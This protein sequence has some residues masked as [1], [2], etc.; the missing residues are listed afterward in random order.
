MNFNELGWVLELSLPLVLA[1]WVFYIYF[2]KRKEQVFRDDLGRIEAR[3]RQLAEARDHFYADAS[4]EIRTPLNAVLG[5]AHM[6]ARTPLDHRQREMLDGIQSA[7]DNLLR[8]LDDLLDAS[9]M[10]A[11]MLRIEQRPFSLREV[12]KGVE[13]L[14]SIKMLEKRLAFRVE[15]HPDTPDTLLGDPARLT[16]ILA[17]LIG[18]AVK[19]TRQGYVFLLAEEI[20]TIENSRPPD[21]PSGKTLLRFLVK[22]TGPGI[23]PDEQAT[24]FERFRQM[25]DGTSRALGGVGLGLAISREL[26]KLMEGS[27]SVESHVGFGTTFLVE[28]PFAVSMQSIENQLIAAK[29]EPAERV[30]FLNKK[31]LVVDDNALNRKLAMLFLKECGCSATEAETGQEAL[32]ILRHKTFDAVFMDIQLPDMDGYTVTQAIRSELK[33]PLPIIALTGY[34]QRGEREKCL[35]IGMDEYLQK[36]VSEA[37]LRMTLG[38]F[39]SEKA[40]Q[41]IDDEWVTK[42]NI[43]SLQYLM[44]LSKGRRAFVRQMLDMFAGQV[45]NELAELSAAVLAADFSRIKTLAHNLRST[46][47]YVGMN[48]RGLAE[49]E[50]LENLAA[51]KKEIGLLKAQFSRIEGM[52]NTAVSA[53]VVAD[54]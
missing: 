47:A 45:P 44:D 21:R 12:L 50:R 28:I 1:G 27:I 39:F 15:I 5:F 24:I 34:S 35:S 3:A 29:S 30:F 31:V 25:E 22:D 4:H 18:N 37:D 14:F 52:L 17:N 13:T 11:G 26:C 20:S 33:N 49:I 36:P 51:E 10:E 42:E 40:T 19:F 9:K 7:G 53:A 43:L 41:A 2:Q 6:L 23:P 54:F 8:L 32:E 38:L 48:P 46:A 16:Q